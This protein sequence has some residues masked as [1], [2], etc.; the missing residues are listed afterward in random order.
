MGVRRILESNFGR[1]PSIISSN[2]RDASDST[3]SRIVHSNTLGYPRCSIILVC[4]NAGSILSECVESVR[5]HTRDY[6]MILVDNASTDGSLECLKRGPDT[7][8]VNLRSNIGYARANNVGLAYSRGNYVVLLNPDAI[9]TA[10][11]LDRLV[12]EAETSPRIGIVAPKLLRPGDPPTLDSTGHIYQYWTGTSS[13]RGQGERDTGRYD[14]DT[15]LPSCCFAAALIKKEVFESVGILDP[16]LFTLYDDVDFGLRARLAGWRVVFRPDSIV[17]HLRGG[18]TS[19]PVKDRVSIS[20]AGSAYQLHTILKI[21]QRKNAVFVGGRHLLGFLVRIVAGI[22]NRDGSYARGYLSAAIWT[23][24]NLPIQ[25]RM[26]TQRIRKI[27]DRVLVPVG[28]S[29]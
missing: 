24:A 9:V 6:E 18:S 28:P 26:A 23:F 20:K 12:Q 8:F 5:R 29:L 16:H 21:Y 22:K 3:G 27:S 2:L 7:R 17:Y 4:R 15:E 19:G 14:K 1:L 25:E 10:G 11:W 13:D